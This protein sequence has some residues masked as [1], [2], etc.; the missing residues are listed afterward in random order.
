MAS[1][2]EL[3]LIANVFLSYSV[4]GFPL[5]ED[6]EHTCGYKVGWMVVSFLISDNYIDHKSRVRVFD[7]FLRDRVIRCATCQD[8]RHFEAVF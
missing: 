3:L 4:S 1:T 8:F 5:H 7:L 6:T 2:S